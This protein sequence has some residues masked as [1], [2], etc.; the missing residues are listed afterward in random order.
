MKFRLKIEGAKGD[1]VSRIEMDFEARNWEAATEYVENFQCQLG[2]RRK[3]EITYAPRAEDIGGLVAAY[4]GAHEDHWKQYPAD[5]RED[6]IKAVIKGETP[7]QRL[8]TYLEWEGIIGWAGTIYDICHTQ[9]AV[10]D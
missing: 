1:A 4:R 2:V 6:A 8:R 7:L 3:A 5:K 10:K 9:A